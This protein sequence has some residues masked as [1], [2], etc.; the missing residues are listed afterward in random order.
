MKRNAVMTAVLLVLGVF[1]SCTPG[2]KQQRQAVA[3]SVIFW[4]N[5]DD[6]GTTR[7]MVE[8]YN[9]TNPAVKVE[10][11]LVPGA[12]TEVSKLM[13]A[14]RSGTGPDIYGL[15]RFTI[16]ERA[17]AGLLEDI[18]DHVNR[19]DPDYGGNHL[20]YAWA[21]TQYNG[22]TWGIP[23][24]TDTRALYYRPDLMREA[25]IDPGPLDPRNGPVTIAQLNEIAMKLNVTDA[26]GN[27]TRIG[28]VPWA[29]QGW[30][31]G[32]GYAFGGSFADLQAK[33]V[34]PLNPG[35]VAA[36]Q[37]FYDTAK[38]LDPLKVRTFMSTYYPPN[39]PPQQDAFLTGH[40]AIVVGGSWMVESI[41]RYAPDIE[42][43]VTYM[44]VLKAGDPPS[45]WAGGWSLVVPKGAKQAE[46]A[47]RFMTWYAGGDGQRLRCELA[48]KAFLPTWVAL[49]DDDSLFIPEY[50]F[51][52]E[53]LKVTKSRPV[54]PIGALYWDQLSIAQD[55]MATNSKTPVEALT[56]VEQQAQAQYD[57]FK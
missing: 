45:T 33:K 44:P 15:D 6:T 42:Y 24:G 48:L 3:G 13:T 54:L 32:F 14:V 27:Y 10:L 50:A 55:D 22:R 57:K 30:H 9:A 37:Y 11:V 49:L 1:L 4:A 53:L 36:Y 26:Q 34:T 19:I 29:N 56:V 17:A 52:R 23:D 25:G 18:T 39:N 40:Q 7:K 2:G 47:I 21:E 41:K 8:A 46:G 31:Y 12:E 35:V 51:F 20:N 38:A 43:G 5:S 28:F 16:G